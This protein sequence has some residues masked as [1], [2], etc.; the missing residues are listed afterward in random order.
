MSQAGSRRRLGWLLAVLALLSVGAGF[1]I[2]RA[3]R[4]RAPDTTTGARAPERGRAAPALWAA[5]PDAPRGAIE[6]IVRAPDGKPYQGALVAAVPAAPDRERPKP[7][8]VALSTGGGRFRLENLPAGPYAASATAPGFAPAFKGELSLLPR[9]APR[10]G[11]LLVGAAGTP[12]RGDR[13]ASG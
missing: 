3:R 12:V 5:D 4:H 10:R 9:Q 11:A 7:A 13:G 1:F 8:A 2:M 6:G